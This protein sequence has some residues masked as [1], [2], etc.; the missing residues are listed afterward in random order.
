MNRDPFIFI[1]VYL[2]FAIVTSWIWAPWWVA[3]TLTFPP[4]VLTFAEALS[5]WTGKDEF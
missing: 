4:T 5:Y 1:L 3:M 2:L